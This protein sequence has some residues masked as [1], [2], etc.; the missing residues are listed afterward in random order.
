VGFRK[1]KSS[2]GGNAGNALGRVW[3]AVMMTKMAEEASTLFFGCGGERRVIISYGMEGR[4]QLQV[5]QGER[6][7]RPQ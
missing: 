6:E 4:E 3:F 7:L 1:R 5:I 2:I